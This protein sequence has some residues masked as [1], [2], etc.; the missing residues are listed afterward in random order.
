MV[1]VESIRSALNRSLVR[2]VATACGRAM[3]EWYGLDDYTSS[4]GE[5]EPVD[6]SDDEASEADF[7]LSSP[8]ANRKAPVPRSR[9]KPK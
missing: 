5:P 2:R 3:T 9:L 4:E 6:D 7:S 8:L 1:E